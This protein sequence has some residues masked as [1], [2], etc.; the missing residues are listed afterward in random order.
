MQLA[1]SDRSSS[2]P[3]LCAFLAFLAATLGCGGSPAAPSGAWVMT[4]SDEFEGAAGQR[5]DPSKWGA[6]IGGGGWGNRQLEYDQA[7]NA[8][9]DGQGHLAVIAQRTVYTN[10]AASYTSAR[11]VTKGR[12]EQAYGKFEARIKLPTGQGLWPAFWLLGAN[13]DTNAWPTCGEID[14][15]EARGQEPRLNHGSLHG[16]GYSGGHAITRTL[17]LPGPDGFDAGFHV[18]SVEW[19]VGQIVFKV[20]D[21]IYHSVRASALPEGTRWVYD[22]PFFVVL[23]VAVGGDYVGSPGGGVA[24]PQTMLVDYVRAWK[25]AP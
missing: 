23:N 7:E 9:L 13:G 14:I 25:R 24:F 6:D 18:F 11:L 10:G 8:T 1:R 19:D 4:W 22:H 20:D 5:P 16:P 21:Q 12:F 3:L 15:M 17:E 2:V